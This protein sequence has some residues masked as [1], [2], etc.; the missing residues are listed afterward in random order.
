ME[1]FVTAGCAVQHTLCVKRGISGVVG[2]R[3]VLRV[4]SCYSCSPFTLSL[5]LVVLEDQTE[6]S[7]ASQ[8]RMSQQ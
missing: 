2:G 6:I 7:F 5:E 3:I 8:K 1:R 4:L